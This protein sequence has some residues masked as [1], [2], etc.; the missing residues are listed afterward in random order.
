MFT[1]KRDN[2]FASPEPFHDEVNLH[3]DAERGFAS[4]SQPKDVPSALGLGS[5]AWG[6]TGVV[7]VCHTKPGQL[8]AAGTNVI[9]TY[10]TSYC[11]LILQMSTRCHSQQ[12]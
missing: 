1:L 7:F 8:E 6:G 9:C 12:S 10:E 4:S 5:S 2:P 3:D 11:T